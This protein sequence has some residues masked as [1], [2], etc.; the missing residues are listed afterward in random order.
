MKRHLALLLAVL[1]MVLAFAGCGKDD[2]VADNPDNTPDSGENVDNSTGNE[3]YGT[4]RDYFTAI[5]N[6]L[7]VLTSTNT[8]TTTVA[9]LCAVYLYMDRVKADKSGWEWTLELAA[10]FPR[11]V[12]ERGLVWE[13]KIR[14]DFK[15]SNGDPITVDDI[16]FTYQQYADPYQQN[17][18]AST[19]T[20]NAYCQIKNIYEYQM[21]AYPWEEVGVEKIDDYTF[22]VELEEPSISLNVQR[23]LNRPLVYKPLYE[24]CMNEDFTATRYGTSINTY[25]CA[26]QFVLEEWIPDGKIVLK[27]NPDY[28]YQDDIKIEYYTFIQVP[29][30]NTALQLFERGEI[31]YVDVPY[32]NWEAYGED[33]RFFE[34]YGDSLMYAFVNLGNPDQGGV[35][36]NLNY[37]KALYRGIDRTEIAKTLG[38][39]P[40]SRLVRRAVVGDPATGKAFIDFEADYVPDPTTI[41]DVKKANEYLTKA[42]EECGITYAETR[43]LYTDTATHIKGAAEIMQKQYSEAFGNKMDLVMHIV[44]AG[45]SSSLRRWNP[46]NPNAYDIALGSLLPSANDPRS[47]FTY[48]RSDYSPPRFCYNNPEFD[49]VY[50]SIMNLHLEE[51]NEAIIEGCQTLE[52]MIL[53]D[54]V[55]IPL[56]ERPNK[57][58]FNEKVKLPAD[59][60]ISGFG[61][62][63]RWATIEK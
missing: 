27:R 34:Y 7:N 41:Y 15:W 60:Y 62:G 10:Q 52:K 56:Y 26:G 45:Q 13:V 19:L 11:Q 30:A 25:M 20:Q 61:F 55:I 49:A 8:S 12:D 43:V 17:L 1:M 36:G 9:S 40:A 38:S 44:P 31:D 22:R 54:L 48:Y 63:V 5:P 59:G 16:I 57:V 58:L 24:A 29:D 50:E 35:L 23:M 47:T 53:D 18:T 2:A 3:P 39:H 28:P 33:P 32:T 42:F 4:F 21:G 46:D 6:T 51:D 14:D 37:R